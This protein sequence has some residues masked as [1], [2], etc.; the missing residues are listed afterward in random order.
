MC[1]RI[2]IAFVD[3]DRYGF[4]KKFIKGLLTDIDYEETTDDPDFI[5]CGDFER[6][7]FLRYDGVRIFV[8]CEF[9]Y[10]DF[11]VYD[12]A[13]DSL[14]INMSDR[15]LRVPFYY[16]RDG[17]TK[18]FEDALNMRRIIP[19]NPLERKFANYMVSNGRF[20]NP[21]RHGFYELLSNYKKVD[22]GGRFANNIGYYVED[23]LSFQSNYKFSLAFENEAFPGYIT[24][25]IVEAYNAA[26]VPIY[27]G[28]NDIGVE[29][30]RDAFIDVND[31]DSEESAIEYIKKVDSDNDLYLKILNTPLV[32][33]D[34]P[35]LKLYKEEGIKKYLLNIIN[36]GR[37]KAYRRSKYGRVEVIESRYK[38]DVCSQ[39]AKSLISDFDK[40]LEQLKSKKIAIY[41]AGLIGL[42]IC[43]KLESYG[44]K[45]EYIVDRMPTSDKYNNIRIITLNDA[46]LRVGRFN[47]VNT[48][49]AFGDKL[50]DLYGKDNVVDVFDFY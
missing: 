47:L 29:F 24:E 45:P 21:F 7:D 40:I 46:D 35:I 50:R 26:T 14:D 32:R 12:Y 6:H 27:W 17:T 5:F 23:K 22:S 37:E 19:E 49:Y 38:R 3:G 1:E 34:S 28:A 15:Y 39:V 33:K 48:V 2:R 11:N 25:K 9:E 8:G 43:D 41:G 13:I 18:E 20:C 16:W 30:N 42:L 10:P 4:L 36:Q 31:F 44:I